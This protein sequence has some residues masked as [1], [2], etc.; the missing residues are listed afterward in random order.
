MHAEVYTDGIDEITV[1]GAIVRV[2]L[3]SLSP[4]ERDANNAEKWDIWTVKPDGLPR[5]SFPREFHF[6]PDGSRVLVTGSV[7]GLQPSPTPASLL[8]GA[9]GTS[10]GDAI[11]VPW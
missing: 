9:T 8:D 11:R 3:V 4:T 7:A 10:L 5:F 2:D 1:G 6:S